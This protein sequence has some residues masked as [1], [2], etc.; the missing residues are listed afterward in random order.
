[1][2]VVGTI[3]PYVCARFG[4]TQSTPAKTTVHKDEQN[5]TWNDEALR[6]EAGAGDAVTVELWDQDVGSRDDRVGAVTLR[7]AELPVIRREFRIAGETAPDAVLCISA[8][9]FPGAA[10]VAATVG[11]REG[12][13]ASQPRPNVREW[14]AEVPGTNGAVHAGVRYKG[15]RPVVVV[16]QTAAESLRDSAVRIVVRGAAH[17]QKVETQFDVTTAPDPSRLPPLRRVAGKLKVYSTYALTDPGKYALKDV[18][19]QIVR[20]RTLVR[21]VRLADVA[22]A[23]GWAGLAT[24]YAEAKTLLKDAFFDDAKQVVFL[25][26]GPAVASLTCGLGTQRVAWLLTPAGREQGLSV[27]VTH[28]SI[29]ERVLKVYPAANEEF[30]GRPFAARCAI[31]K[32]PGVMRLEQVALQLYKEEDIVEVPF[33]SIFPIA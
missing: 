14:F 33:L 22:K 13:V 32:Q 28:S 6:G 25:E 17:S 9:A 20:K 10:H 19:V 24:T 15:T 21:T 2:D 29:N 23:H 7:R 1:M 3:D 4:Q 18:F 16:A 31:A 8:F 12:V 11:A 5:P 30:G 27:D 26:E